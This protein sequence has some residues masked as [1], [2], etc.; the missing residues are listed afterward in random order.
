MNEDVDDVIMNE[1]N[2]HSKAKELNIL[3]SA[4]KYYQSRSLTLDAIVSSRQNS[5]S[6]PPKTISFSTLQQS[7][8]TLYDN[9]VLLESVKE[10]MKVMQNSLTCYEFTELE[11]ENFKR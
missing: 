9:I 3:K 1:N 11:N 10:C 8:V 5:E 7:T 4:L 2:N 6:I